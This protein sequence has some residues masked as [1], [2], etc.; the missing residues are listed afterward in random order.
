VES[1]ATSQCSVCAASATLKILGAH[2]Y[3]HVYEG[4]CVCVCVK[5]RQREREGVW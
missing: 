4:G 1:W 5:E 3:M 2:M